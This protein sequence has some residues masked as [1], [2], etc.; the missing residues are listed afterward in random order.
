MANPRRHV[1]ATLW[2]GR[3]MK[4]VDKESPSRQAPK[5]MCADGEQEKAQVGMEY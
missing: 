2:G 3:R 1:K 4:K 5:H